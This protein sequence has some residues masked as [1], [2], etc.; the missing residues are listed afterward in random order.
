MY[1]SIFP[2]DF[3]FMLKNKSYKLTIDKNFIILYQI[4]ENEDDK[5]IFNHQL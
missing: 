3:N 2:V 4:F 1:L 5:I